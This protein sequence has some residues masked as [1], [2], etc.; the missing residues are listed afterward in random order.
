MRTA[1][2]A[3]MWEDRVVAPILA[4]FRESNPHRI[5]VGDGR[6]AAIR[7]WVT[8]VSQVRILPGPLKMPRAHC[9]FHLARAQLA[10]LGLI[11]AVSERG[12]WLPGCQRGDPRYAFGGWSEPVCHFSAPGSFSYDRRRGGSVRRGM[13]GPSRP[14]PNANLNPGAPY[15]LMSH[16]FPQ[17]KSVRAVI[18]DEEQHAADVGEPV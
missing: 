12:T 10:A 15:D 14:L 5:E 1:A 7:K 11:S 4:P 17:L 6:A 18:R 2:C 9:I 16:R 3:G 13:F 8:L